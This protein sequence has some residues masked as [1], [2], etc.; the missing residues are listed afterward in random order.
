MSGYPRETRYGER[1]ALSA[2]R[3][4]AMIATKKAYGK[5]P[6]HLSSWMSM[7]SGFF[8]SCSICVCIDT[9][10]S[11]MRSPSI[12]I[13]RARM[14]GARISIS[15]KNGSVIINAI[16]IREI[17]PDI[18]EDTTLYSSPRP[19]FSRAHFRND[20]LVPLEKAPSESDIQIPPSAKTTNPSAIR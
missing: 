12:S 8:S 9:M 13:T 3:K 14:M 2:I 15:M 19:S 7:R 4:P 18:F 17:F 11:A 16:E 1:Y 20:A 5:N 6:V 10:L